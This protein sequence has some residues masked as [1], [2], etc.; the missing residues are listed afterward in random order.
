MPSAI[1]ERE[2]RG[3][4]SAEGRLL[5]SSFAAAA[6]SVRIRASGP[7]CPAWNALATARPM[8]TRASIGRLPADGPRPRT[9]LEEQVLQHDTEIEP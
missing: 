1:D 9:I 5:R 3:R 4:R 8:P 6:S 2:R 7:G